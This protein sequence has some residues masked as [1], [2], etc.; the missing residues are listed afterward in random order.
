MLDHTGFLQERKDATTKWK[1]LGIC[2]TLGGCGFLGDIKENASTFELLGYCLLA[3]VSGFGAPLQSATNRTI[4][5]HLLST[6]R[7][8]AVSM[9]GSSTILLLGW[10]ISLPF[11]LPRR[12]DPPPKWWYFTGGLLGNYIVLGGALYPIYLGMSS[13]YVIVIVGQLSFS[14]ILDNFGILAP[15]NEISL[16]RIIG[17]ILAFIG[18]L[19]VKFQSS[20]AP[21][22]QANDQ[23]ISLLQNDALLEPTPL[24]IIQG[25]QH[26]TENLEEN[27][28]SEQEVM[29]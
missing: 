10:L 20:T 5:K 21:A 29:E 28:D 8:V 25:P 22:P 18:V 4:A 14:I 6:F 2:F 17:V 3:F 15:K 16:N 27:K 9:T 23:A 7:G 11:D 19:F 12:Y 1:V 26:V 13:Y 24:S